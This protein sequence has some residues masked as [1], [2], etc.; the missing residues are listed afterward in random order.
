MKYEYSQP[1]VA[2][3]S[4]NLKIKLS[5]NIAINEKYYVTLIVIAIKVGTY[6][7][8]QLISIPSHHRIH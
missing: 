5:T 3:I 8:T 2:N 1:H 6:N 4:P 7:K